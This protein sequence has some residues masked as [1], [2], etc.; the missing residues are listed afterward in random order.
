MLEFFNESEESSIYIV[1]IK[2]KIDP[3]YSYDT[4]ELA[5]L[6]GLSSPDRIIEWVKDGLKAKRSGEKV[7]QFGGKYEILGKDVIKYLLLREIRKCNYLE[8]EG[9]E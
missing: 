7:N 4:W 2:T 1:K 9:I 6:F 3:K 8:I 5:D